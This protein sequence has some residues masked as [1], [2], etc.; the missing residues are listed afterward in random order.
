MKIMHFQTEVGLMK[1]MI[2]WNRN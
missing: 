1:I 2:A